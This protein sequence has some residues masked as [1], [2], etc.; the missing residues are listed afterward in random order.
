MYVQKFYAQKNYE[1]GDQFLK[2]V[3]KSDNKTQRV[4]TLLNNVKSRRKFYA[5]RE[6][7]TN[8]LS[9]NLKLKLSQKENK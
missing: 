4:L 1:K 8:F 5:N 7:N 6:D 9:L 2:A 3:E